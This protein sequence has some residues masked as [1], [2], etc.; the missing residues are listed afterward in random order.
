MNIGVGEELAYIEKWFVGAEMWDEDIVTNTDGSKGDC[1]DWLDIRFTYDSE[2]GKEGLT[3]YGGIKLKSNEVESGNEGNW[4]GI[5]VRY[6]N[7][8]TGGQ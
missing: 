5:C 7:W 3:I 4:G 6:W 8:V 1:W 2:A